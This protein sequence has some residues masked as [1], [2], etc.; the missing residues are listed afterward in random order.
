MNWSAVGLQAGVEG[1]GDQAFGA[2]HDKG[3]N[4]QTQNAQGDFGLQLHHEFT[5]HQCGVHAF[6]NLIAQDDRFAH[7]GGKR[8]FFHMT[9]SFANNFFCKKHI[10][11]LCRRTDTI[12]FYSCLILSV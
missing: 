4:A 1:D 8:I 5:A 2:L 7:S 12:L 6:L 9:D 3:S 11:S 10:R